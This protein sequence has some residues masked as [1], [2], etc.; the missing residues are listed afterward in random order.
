MVRVV[1]DLRDS[2]RLPCR[3]ATFAC[4]V[5][6]HKPSASCRLLSNL[7]CL[8]RTSEVR[9]TPSAFDAPLATLHCDSNADLASC[10]ALNLLTLVRARVQASSAVVRIPS[11]LAIASTAVSPARSSAPTPT[12]S[13]PP[14]CSLPP[15]LLWAAGLIGGETMPW[16]LRP[17][18]KASKWERSSTAA[19]AACSRFCSGSAASLALCKSLMACV[20]FVSSVI[21]LRR[22][23]SACPH[24]R[25]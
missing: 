6:I 25:R 14:A 10:H 3:C 20:H 5:A 1:S 8:Y 18:C 21:S 7:Q 24:V 2:V 23:P 19:T 17:T 16:G 15:S 12:A 13:P 22:S 9:S 11:R 4:A